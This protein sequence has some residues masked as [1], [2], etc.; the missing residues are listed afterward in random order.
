MTQGVV[1]AAGKRILIVDD[2]SAYCDA[3]ADILAYAGYRTLRANSVDAAAAMLAEV[4]PD[5]I[6]SDTMMPGADGG[7]LLQVVRSDRR[8]RK[9]QVVTV[10][11]RAMPSHQA[12][13]LAAG[14][15]GFLAKP[16]TAEQLL[17]EIGRQLDRKEREAA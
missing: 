3:I 1:Q 15:S 2:D 10:S 14:A 8:L 11:A 17:A 12:E 7:I 16:F 9:I 13:A 5:I 6:L 4:T